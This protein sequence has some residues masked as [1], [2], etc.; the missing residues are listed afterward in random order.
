MSLSFAGNK[1]IDVEVTL[2]G[3][4]G[5]GSSNLNSIVKL[6][7]KGVMT[8]S[9]DGKINYE[10]EHSLEI[11][12]DNSGAMILMVDLIFKKKGQKDKA[13]A[14]KI[15]ISEDGKQLFKPFDGITMTIESKGF[16]KST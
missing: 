14:K 12:K 15:S 7:D 6:L 8:N 9:S 13:W 16:G 11:K 5:G 1:G 10:I 3:G 2:A 4:Q